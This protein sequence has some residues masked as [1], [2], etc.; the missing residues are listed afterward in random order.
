MSDHVTD[1][2]KNIQT[3][4]SSSPLGKSVIVT[5]GK[6][7]P[8]FWTG[9]SQV[10]VGQNDLLLNDILH[11]PSIKKNLLSGNRLCIDNPIS[12]VFDDCHEFLKD[13]QSNKNLA[14]EKVKEGLYEL[15]L[16][17]KTNTCEKVTLDT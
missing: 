16:K 9:N 2:A 1:D 14:F 11:P 7:I 3:S 6:S 4:D 8:I 17:G 13:R 15:N 10:K 5:N 12:L